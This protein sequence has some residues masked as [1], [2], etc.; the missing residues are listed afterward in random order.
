MLRAVAP[1]WPRLRDTLGHCC[2]FFQVGS[3]YR[4]KRMSQEKEIL[5]LLLSNYLE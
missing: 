5:V 4:D 2:A 1:C 3:G